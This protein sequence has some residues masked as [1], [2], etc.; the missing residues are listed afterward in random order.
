MLRAAGAD[1]EDRE[2]RHAGD[3]PRRAAG[4]PGHGRAR[5]RLEPGRD[6]D[7]GR[8][9]L[10]RLPASSPRC[11]SRGSEV[12]LEGVGINPGRIGLLGILTRMGAAIEVVE[13][14][15]AGREPVATIVARSG[16]LQ[17]DPGRRRRGAAGDRRAAA[18]GAR[19]LLRR[20]RDGRLGRRRAPPQGVGPDRDRGRAACARSAPRSRRPRT[21]SRSPAAA[22]CAAARSR[23]RAITAWRCSAR[24][25]GS[26]RADGVEVAA[27]RRR[28]SAIRASPA[29]SRALLRP[30]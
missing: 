16:P 26:P 6:R 24:S 28:R 27:S 25:P 18:G 5:E 30:A 7:P 29:T 10:R 8:L 15:A 23:P 2:R 21:A 3:D 4:A 22:A 14:A 9:L 12:R 19:R 1:G 11:S 20:R 17:G 13:T